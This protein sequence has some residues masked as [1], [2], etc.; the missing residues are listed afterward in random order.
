MPDAQQDPKLESLT[1]PSTLDD[2]TA[3]RYYPVVVLGEDSTDDADDTIASFVASFPALARYHATHDSTLVGFIS[4]AHAIRVDELEQGRI[5]FTPRIPVLR[6]PGSELAVGEPLQFRIGESSGDAPESTTEWIGLLVVL[7]VVNNIPLVPATDLV[8]RRLRRLID[9]LFSPE[10]IALPR[11]RRVHAGE[12]LP[13]AHVAHLYRALIEHGYERADIQVPKTSLPTET[14]ETIEI[15]QFGSILVLGADGTP[16]GMDRLRAIVVELA[17]HG[18]KGLLVR[19]HGEI[20]SHNVIQKVLAMALACEAVL[21]DDTEASGHL[22]EV[23]AVLVN[24]TIPFVLLRR[25]SRAS[26]AMI[27]PHVSSYRWSE[28]VAYQATPAE[29]VVAA[30]EAARRLKEDKE[31]RTRATEWWR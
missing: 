13:A 12:G 26:T 4:H 22:V 20:I 11:G 10:G 2:V 29:V 24:A 18:R 9:Q 15:P 7:A 21:V 17:A 16:A 30:L 3:R 23:P 25:D 14:G 8:A 5:V 19:E 27:E 6:V 28:V 31:Q 1:V